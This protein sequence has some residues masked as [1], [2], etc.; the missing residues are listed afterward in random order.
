M[1]LLEPSDNIRERWVVVKLDAI[2]RRPAKFAVLVS[3]RGL[4]ND[5][6]KSR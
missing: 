2:P 3:R 6:R 5:M 4:G 1:F